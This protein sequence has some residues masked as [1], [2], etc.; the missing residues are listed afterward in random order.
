MY[1]AEL[2]PPSI[3]GRLVGIYEISVQ[4][5][6]CIG[7]WICYGVSK[8]MTVSRGQWMTPF[9]VQLIPGGLFIL[10]MF[11]IPESP[12]WTARFRTREAAL[13]TLARLRNLPID[14]PYL[15]EEMS[16]IMNVVDEEQILHADRN[17]LHEIRELAAPGNRKRVFIGVMIFTFM[18]WAGSNAINYYSPRI[19]ASIG[20]TGLETGLYATGIYGIV[21]LVCVIIAMYYIVDMVGRRKLLMGGAVIML[22]AMWALGAYVKLA[23]TNTTGHVTSGGIAAAAFVYI[24][25]IGFCFSYAGIPWIYCAEIFPMR[26]RG[27]GMAICTATHWILNFVI[28]RSVPYMISNIGYGTYFV[29]AACLT[30]SVPFVYYFVPETRG[31]SLEE[32]DVIFGVPGAAL[33][34]DQQKDVES[35]EEKAQAQYVE[36]RTLHSSS[37]ENVTEYTKS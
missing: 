33:A 35:Y 32:M 25:A 17:M 31:V 34:P 21:R 24:F 6:T 30:L 28:A 5:G 12:R 19:F 8:N 14:H 36:D 11:L 9:A 29:F 2:A 10:G 1:I 18:Q 22:L 7:F 13:D 15:Q 27:L 23:P 37:S 3:R 16:Q 26:I 4:T 20:I